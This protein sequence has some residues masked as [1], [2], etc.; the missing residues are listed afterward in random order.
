MLALAIGVLLLSAAATFLIGNAYVSPRDSFLRKKAGVWTLV[1][2]GLSLVPLPPQMLLLPDTASQAPSVLDQYAAYGDVSALT[3]GLVWPSGLPRTLYVAL[4]LVTS[5]A[6][7]LAGARI[8]KAG[9]PG[10]RPGQHATAYDT[11]AAGRGRALL[12]LA[13]TLDDALESLARAGIDPRGAE[14]LA[15]DLRDVGRRFAATLPS[16]AGAVYQ[17]VAAKL[18]PLVASVV[19][20]SLLEGAGRGGEIAQVASKHADRG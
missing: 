10:W 9:T 5:V 18:S 15:P 6:A 12:P 7:L 3:R 19:T 13:D 20:R 1:V 14:Q 8:W 17:A 2:L 4:W 16:G 11:S